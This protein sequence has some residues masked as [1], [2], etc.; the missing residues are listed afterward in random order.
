MST[1]RLTIGLPVYNGEVHIAETLESILAQDFTDFELIVGDNASTDG[2]RDILRDFAARDERIILKLS[3]ENLGA[4]WNYNRLVTAARGELFKWAAADDLIAPTY[5]SSC[6]NELD[7]HPEAV[8][9]YAGTTL[10][11]DRGVRIRDHA[12]GLHLAQSQPWERL[13]QFAA[14]RW[15]CN[16][17]FGVA[18]TAVMRSDTTLITANRSSDVTFLAQ[19]A[20]AGQIREVPDR[21]FYRRVV[22]ESASLGAHNRRAVAA[23]FDP[24]RSAGVMPPMLRVFVDINRWILTRRGAIVPRVRT[25]AAFSAAWTKRNAGVALWRARRR[26]RGGAVRGFYASVATASDQS[27]TEVAR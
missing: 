11:D 10:I 14:K 15:L 26:T 2:T 4:A 7:R 5:L 27:R 24:H 18:R 8:L 23:F 21:L 6:I 19:M 13:R 22:G 1:P 3:D 12:D 16:P 9:A 17:C 25:A 20:V